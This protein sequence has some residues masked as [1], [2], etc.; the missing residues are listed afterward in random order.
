MHLARLAPFVLA[1]LLAGCG[2]S[3]PIPIPVDLSVVQ[4]GG[5]ESGTSGSQ[6]D[7]L[8]GRGSNRDCLDDAVRV[9][10]IADETTF[11]GDSSL[12]V[13][14]L[15][16]LPDSLAASTEAQLP[17]VDELFDYPVVVNRR[18]LTWIDAYLG[19]IR[20]SFEISLRRS[21]RYLPMARRIFAE[22][23]IPQDLAFLA[24]VESGFRPH[25]RSHKSAC[26]LWQFMRGTAKLHGLRCNDLV[27]ERF[28]PERSTRAAAEHLRL[29]HERYEDWH[30]V[31]A[32]YNAGIGKV[33]KAIRRSGSD[34]FWK[35][36]N[37]RHL[38]NETR[39][40]VPA[41][42][43]ATILAKSPAAYGLTEETDCPLLYDTLTVRVATDLRVIAEAT[44]LDLAELRDLNPALLYGQTPK[45]GGYAVRLPLATRE[46]VALALADIPASQRLV[47]H[48]HRV[49]RG[50][51]LS[52]LA[53][54]YGTTVRAIQAE[55]GMGRS[56]LIRV[57]KMLRVPNRLPKN[58]AS[59]AAK[60]S[61]ADGP[62]DTA[63]P[64]FDEAQIRVLEQP[65]PDLGRV[66]STAHVVDEAR[67]AL[68]SAEETDEED[69]PKVRVHIV[70]RGDTLYGIARRYGVPLSRIY[71][72]NNL[73]PKSV[74]RPGQ[75]V[76]TQR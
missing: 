56:T 45:T 39:N 14:D 16:D 27:D 59:S 38:R 46:T 3:R 42:L 30:L 63:P 24:H 40:F 44:G 57:G 8:V 9:D 49:R 52:G 48:R 60:R 33:D 2:G 25:A 69:A 37:T 20:K 6:A 29:L 12:T 72:L 36:A 74:I 70:Q 53:R 50:D 58:L 43:A 1:A 75:R 32:A 65:E 76:V 35:I 15:P 73:G 4:N 67:T 34:D 19:R 62:L 7:S 13:L 17:A 68:A 5:G 21:G 10:G 23:G 54:R 61:S 18:V 26:G 64:W 22:E 28:D 71:R 66:S 55:N 31:L 11:L 41:I 47:F 51:T